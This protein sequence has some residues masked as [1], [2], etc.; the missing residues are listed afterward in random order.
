[1]RSP[2]RFLFTI[3]CVLSLCLIFYNVL[4]WTQSENQN[5]NCLDKSVE[6]IRSLPDLNYLETLDGQLVS[7]EEIFSACDSNW[8]MCCLYRKF[9]HWQT[10]VREIISH[11]PRGKIHHKIRMYHN[12]LTTCYPERCNPRKTHGDVA[13][14]YDE[15]GRFMGIAV[16]MG[17][18]MYCSLPV[19]KS[20]N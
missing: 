14:F 10:E 1:M 16:Y 7:L 2:S 18:G 17:D 12:C 11:T 19:G 5:S 13:E 6:R 4:G 15:N 8:P 20:K 3:A 9:Y